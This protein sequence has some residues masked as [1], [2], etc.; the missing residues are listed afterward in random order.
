MLWT[1]ESAKKDIRMILRL[2]AEANHLERTSACDQQTISFC[3]VAGTI[4]SVQ[5]CDLDPENKLANSTTV[6]LWRTFL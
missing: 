6:L 3:A 2:F 5:F 1:N 4:R